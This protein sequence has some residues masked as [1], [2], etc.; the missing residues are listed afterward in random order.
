LSSYIVVHD[1]IFHDASTF[2]S[3]VRNLF[4]RGVPMSQLLR[5]AEALLPFWTSMRARI[6]GLRQRSYDRLSPGERRYFDLLSR[7]VDAVSATVE[8]LVDRQ[9][10]LSEGSKGSTRNPITWEAFQDK[11]RAYQAAVQRYMSVG[12]E[13]NDAAPVVFEEHSWPERRRR[14]DANL[15]DGCSLPVRPWLAPASL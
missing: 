4:G 7:Y 10:L 1:R 3:V 11:E 14:L 8:A 15:R 6:E 2:K 12:G 9:R 5:D 13:L